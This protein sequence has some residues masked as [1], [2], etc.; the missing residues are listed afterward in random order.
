MLVAALL[1]GPSSTA[2][3]AHVQPH[4]SAH[5]A[6]RTVPISSSSGTGP[7]WTR[8]RSPRVNGRLGA[9]TVKRFPVRSRADAACVC[10]R[11][12]PCRRRSAPSR[13]APRSCTRSRTG[14][15][16]STCRRVAR[17]G[18]D[19]ER[20]E[21]RRAVGMAEDRRPGCVGRRRPARTR[22]SSGTSTPAS[23]TTTRTWPRTSGRTRPSA[24]GRSASDDDG[25]GY[26]DD[27]YGI[28]T[29]NGDTD[30]M[31]DNDHGTHTAG[32][33]G[34]VGDNGVG[35]TG[36]NWNVQVLPCKS[37]DVERQRLDREHHRVLPVHGHREGRRQRHHRDEQLLR[38]LPGGVRLRPGDDGR[39]RGDGRCRHPVRR[40]RRQ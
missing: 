9:T 38:P 19:A 30:P 8:P 5:G 23:T 32:T 33:I 35:V 4:R 14:S 40:R 1:W 7:A 2:A 10:D 16:T 13:R 3:P 22:W 25:N 27:C 28:D 34:A 36:L 18:P 15:R 24:T 26:V 37:H 11:R 31:D 17:A 39:H 21:V 6:P 29:I 20:P 12:S